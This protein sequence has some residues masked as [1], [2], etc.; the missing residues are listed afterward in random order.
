MSQQQRAGFLGRAIE[1]GAYGFTVVGATG[2]MVMMLG[3]VLNVVLRNVFLTSIRGTDELCIYLLVLCGFGAVPYALLRNRHVSIDV[4]LVHLS[5]RV[6][7]WVTA[8]AF[9]VSAGMAGLATYAFITKAYLAVLQNEVYTAGILTPVWPAR[10]I[11]AASFALLLVAQFLLIGRHIA[12]RGTVI[13]P[14][15]L[16]E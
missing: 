6:R 5:D 13:T 4:V 2:L 11:I 3:T 15:I 8:I 16:Q 7:Y 10:I 12:R 1:A 9:A 14:T